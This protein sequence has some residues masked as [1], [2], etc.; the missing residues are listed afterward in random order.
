MKN[1]TLAGEKAYPSGRLKLGTGG[2]FGL[3]D[4][5]AVKNLRRRIHN[6]W[7]ENYKKVKISTHSNGVITA[8]DAWPEAK[9]RIEKSKYSKRNEKCG[10]MSDPMTAD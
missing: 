6:A 1:K 5:Q 2:I 10:T 7:E 8:H 9:E 4:K 3:P